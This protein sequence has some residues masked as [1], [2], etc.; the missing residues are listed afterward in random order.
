MAKYEITEDRQITCEGRR[1]GTFDED[2]RITLEVDEISGQALGYLKKLV[3][4]EKARVSVRPEEEMQP[5]ATEVPEAP[6]MDPRYGDKTPAYAE[7]MF[8][9]FPDKA[10]MIYAGRKIM[11]R[12][13]PMAIGPETPPLPS[14][15]ETKTPE[16]G[17]DVPESAM[18]KEAPEQWM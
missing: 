14:A 10:A 3:A 16:P 2:G 11:G 7:W 8:K 15:A 13:M 1:I 17:A 4:D 5:H 6:P 18:G 9:F 12:Q